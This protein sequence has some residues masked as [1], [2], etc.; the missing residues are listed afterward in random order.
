MR[1]E[2]RTCSH[3][4]LW[5]ACNRK[6]EVFCLTLITV[7]CTA[8]IAFWLNT[9][10]VESCYFR[11]VSSDSLS[12]GQSHFD[13]RSRSH[14]KVS[15]DHLR[16]E[17]NCVILNVTQLIC[18]LWCLRVVPKPSLPASLNV[19]LLFGEIWSQPGSVGWLGCS[20]ITLLQFSTSLLLFVGKCDCSQR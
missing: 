6:A 20:L 14:S 19:T 8:Q 3:P 12:L 1:V 4:F 11:L 18:S 16:F 13:R 17:F 10:T 9:L 5:Y 2:N 15:K 7:K